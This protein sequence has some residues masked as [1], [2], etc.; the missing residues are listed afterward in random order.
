MKVVAPSSSVRRS[1]R[2][3]AAPVSSSGIS[4]GGGGGG[5]SPDATAFQLLKNQLEKEGEWRQLSNRHG[6]YDILVKKGHNL[7]DAGEWILFIIYH[8]YYTS[9]FLDDEFIVYLL[10]ACLL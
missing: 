3:P 8:S 2:S 5:R 1:S 10:L 6:I 9:S 7:G 4:N